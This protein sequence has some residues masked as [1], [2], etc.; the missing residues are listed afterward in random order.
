M[1]QKFRAAAVEGDV[2][3]VFDQQGDFFPMGLGVIGN[4][5]D[6][7]EGAFFIKIVSSRFESDGDGGVIRELCETFREFPECGGGVL[8]GIGRHIIAERNL[9]RFHRVSRLFCF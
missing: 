5:A 7:L 8:S 3:P 6:S 9:N 2:P 4:V 1:K